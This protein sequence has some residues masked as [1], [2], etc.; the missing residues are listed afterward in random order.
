MQLLTISNE[1][2][3][4]LIQ[5]LVGAYKLASHHGAFVHSLTGLGRLDCALKSW[6]NPY[7][8]FIHGGAKIGD[9]ADVL[10]DFPCLSALWT[11]GMYE[12][13]RT[14]DQ[15]LKRD[16]KLGN[17]HPGAHDVTLLKLEFARV[18]MP[19]AKF[20]NATAFPGDRSFLSQSLGGPS[21]WGWIVADKTVIYRNELADKVLELFEKFDHTEASTFF[22]KQLE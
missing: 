21:G 8:A 7:Y 22:A 4:R 19:L 20:E 11:M 2:S 10:T 14:L 9:P 6:D 17:N 5:W 3:M 18:R 15:K 13:L 12:V 1:Y 16:A